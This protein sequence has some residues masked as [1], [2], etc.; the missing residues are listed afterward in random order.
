MFGGGGEFGML[1]KVLTY[2]SSTSFAVRAITEWK[3]K[4]F[5]TNGQIFLT[6]FWSFI[7]RAIFPNKP[8][9]YGKMLI[10]EK[11]FPGMAETGHT[12]SFGLYLDNLI[13]FGWMGFVAPVFLNLKFLFQ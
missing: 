9:A 12:P 8:F 11:F 2:K 1:N 3:E 10:L 4:G 6:S 7:P 5:S 13:D